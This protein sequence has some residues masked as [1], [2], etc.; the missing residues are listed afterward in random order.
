MK[1]LVVYF[2]A[3]GTTRDVAKKLAQ[4]IE[5]D[6]FEIVPAKPYTARDLNW[7][8]KNARTTLEAKQ[9]N[10]RPEMA[11]KLKDA[12]EYDTIYLGFPIWW[13]S[14]PKIVNTFLESIDTSNKTI[15]LFATSGGSGLGNTSD[16][17]KKSCDSRTK[18]VS[19]TILNAGQD[20]FSL[21]QWA[22]KY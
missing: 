3:T 16:D 5:A 11:N 14:A 21:K 13:Y 1:K 12:N 8:D 4:A 22:E 10:I 15:I 20:I 17:L 6:I 7:M 9:E 19:G 2:S 18:I